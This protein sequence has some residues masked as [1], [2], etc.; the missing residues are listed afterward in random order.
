MWQFIFLTCAES[1]KILFKMEQRKLIKLGNSSFAIALPKTWVDK[2][3]LKK[4]ENVFLEENSNGEIIISVSTRKDKV[5]KEI[6]LDVENKEKAEIAR[7]IISAYVS[8]NTTI[9]ITGANEKIKLSKE[10]SKNFLNLEIEEESANKIVLKDLLDLKN[11][12]I[13]NFV[14]RMDNNTKEMFSLLVSLLSGKR[15]SK[16]II[17][18]LEEIDKDTT[19]LYFF[20]WRFM[21]L[22]IDNPGIQSELK[23]N[24]K[25]FVSF[26]WISYNLEQIGDELKRMARKIEKAGDKTQ[27]KE[28]LDLINENYNKSMKAFFDKNKELSK[29]VILKK[30]EM[31][32]NSEKLAEISGFEA[33][34][35]KLQQI[36]AAIHNNS[37]M[38][39][40][41]L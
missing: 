4:G 15:K 34:S 14:R 20:V 21:N 9:I 2:S 40:Y 36:N 7:D 18:E 12:S 37:K 23:M 1:S 26:F 31:I 3:G 35:E 6:F 39:F 16:E 24:P 13:E 30:I 22:G 8:G 11:I 5:E 41:G 25:S 29:E 17:N 28:L 27:L 10:I 32:K 19:R 33:V 38:V